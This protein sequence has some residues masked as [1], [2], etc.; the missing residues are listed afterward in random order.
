MIRCHLLLRIPR[1]RRTPGCLAILCTPFLKRSQDNTTLAS[2]YPRIPSGTVLPRTLMQKARCC[3]PERVSARP[4]GGRA[5][6]NCGQETDLAASLHLGFTNHPRVANTA[7][8]G[9]SSSGVLARRPG[10]LPPAGVR[11]D[12][13]HPPDVTGQPTKTHVGSMRQCL[14]PRRRNTSVGAGRFP[15]HPRTQRIMACAVDDV[16]AE[17]GAGDALILSSG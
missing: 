13:I 5:Q 3:A 1:L 9:A 15:V 7:S 6:Q 16:K 14:E 12:W 11:G 4:S 17:T 8:G 10:Y 2:S